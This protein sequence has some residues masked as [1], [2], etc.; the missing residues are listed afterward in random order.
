[1]TITEGL[2]VGSLFKS[3]ATEVFD[4]WTESRKAFKSIL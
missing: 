3:Q 4:A 2:D 1:M